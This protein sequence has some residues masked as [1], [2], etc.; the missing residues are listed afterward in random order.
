MSARDKLKLLKY[1]KLTV[2][3]NVKN[4]LEKIKKENPKINAF[5]DIRPEIA[6]REA[7]YL[8]KN[9]E[10][11]KNKKLF[12]LCIGVKA[13]INVKGYNSSCAS[14]TLRNY[15]APYDATVIKRIKD[16]GGIVIG[17]TN[18]DE[19]CCGS[20][21]ETSAFG[22]TKN[23]AALDRIPGGSSSG[24]AASIAAGFCDMALGSDTGGSIRN[25]ASHCGVVGVK[26]SYGLV[27]RYGLI[28]LSMSLD[29]I[30][31]FARNVEDA[32]LLLNVIKGKDEKDATS[33]ESK[34]I[35]TEKLG[36]ITIGIPEVKCDARILKLINNKVKEVASKNKWKIEKIN[37]PHIDLGIQTYYPIC[38]TEFFSGTRK[39]DGRR[40]GKKIEDSCGEE[41]LRRI[42][43]GQEISQAEYKGKYYRKALQAKAL[44]AKE[45]ELA[46]K[47][48]DAIIMP[49][50]PIL[51]WE[52]G[53]GSKMKPEEIYAAD[54]LTVLANLA[55]IPA[56]SVPA[57]KINNIPV[58]LQIT[59][60]KFNEGKMFSIAKKFEGK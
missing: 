17:I 11:M 30:G 27:S 60:G 52:L 18:C 48:V 32:L 56:I 7:E 51:P 50:F 45:F 39:F 1:G 4:F 24:S 33:F 59:V 38:Y 21:G 29:Q 15:I 57:G 37:L 20:S 10:R 31:C 54:A 47:K 42:L 34:N 12:G 14:N 23:P 36:K 35:I 55:E 9:K 49:V 40:Y 5:I 3:E 41:V 53:E 13:A 44:I 28:D 25:P 16:E 19:F 22:F 8:D 2:T 46:F 43:G 58:G 6:L 26:P